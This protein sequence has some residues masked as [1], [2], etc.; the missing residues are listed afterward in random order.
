M[1]P[2]KRIDLAPG[3][4]CSTTWPGSTPVRRPAPTASWC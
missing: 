1:T 3:R 4:W 2:D